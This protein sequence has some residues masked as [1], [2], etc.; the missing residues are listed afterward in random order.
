M[1][2]ERARSKRVYKLSDE[3]TKSNVRIAKKLETVEAENEKLKR[4][5]ATGQ[6]RKTKAA[7]PVT[8]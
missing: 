3:L 4:Q 2:S 5:L 6:K 8:V 1:L 7:T